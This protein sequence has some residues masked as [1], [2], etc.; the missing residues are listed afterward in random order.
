MEPTGA[1]YAVAAGAGVLA[2]GINALA[3][4]GSLVSFPALHFVGLSSID[5]NVTNIVALTPGYV[6]GSLGQRDDLTGRRDEL[7]RLA[8]PAAL[9]ALAGA[10]ILV[11]VAA[12][13]FTAV[14]P[15]LIVAACAA[16]A[17]Q[18]RIRRSVERRRARSAVDGAERGRADQV[19]VFLSCVYGGFFG[20]GLGI[21]LLAV[22]GTF[23]SESLVRVNALKQVAGASLLGG[24]VGG[25]LVRRVDARL[26]RALVIAYGLA[27][28]I[29]YWV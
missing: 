23:S 12:T 8:P 10:A 26:L 16:L 18:D 29:R 9:G 5:A 15:F 21:I 19:A 22:L 1:G 6:A 24:L 17:G 28:A 3:G 20:A 14:V 2:G 4:G 11:T 13:S 27:V 7:R 25:R